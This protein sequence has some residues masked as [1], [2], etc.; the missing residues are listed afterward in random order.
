MDQIFVGASMA[1]PVH[2]FPEEV[3]RLALDALNLAKASIL[4][5]NHFLSSA[6]AR[7]TV[8]PARLGVSFA[9]DGFVLAFDCACVLA[10]FKR[11][12][13]P[14]QH[15]LLHSI[16]H[17]LFLHPYRGAVEPALWDLACDIA[18]ERVVAELLGPRKGAR[19]TGIARIV[20]RVE[21]DMC[22]RADAERLYRE[23]SRGRWESEIA[24][25]ADLTAR[26]SHMLWYAESD[27]P[28]DFQGNATSGRT[29][30]SGAKTAQSGPEDSTART[31]ASDRQAHE[32]PEQD[33]FDESDATSSAQIREAIATRNS[34]SGSDPASASSAYRDGG[35]SQDQHPTASGAA[36]LAPQQA[37][38]TR[39][40][41]DRA[42][43]KGEWRDEA[44]SLAIHLQTLAA[45]TGSRLTEFVADLEGA[46]RTADDY[47]DFL[48][49]F[50]AYGEVMRISEDEFDYNFYT[51]GM[52]LYGDTPLI[53]PLEYRDERRIR[54]FVVV[55]D[56]SESV[57]G[58]AV[59]AFVRATFNVL[60]T[61][62]AFFDRICLR[63]LQCDNRVLAD[64]VIRDPND[65][66][67]WSDGMKIRGGGGTDFRPA[68]DYIDHLVDDGQLHSVDGLLYFTDGL[69]IYPD[70]APAYK[71]AFVFYDE[72]LIGNE[73]PAW[74]LRVLLD[75]GSLRRAGQPD[76]GKE[77]QWI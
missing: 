68:F 35:P 8:R 11:D 16:V 55:I 10:A 73:V 14:S 60:K 74:A 20:S 47:V 37:A 52:S 31:L 42:R 43:S 36:P 17:C 48:R 2:P 76:G 3:E 50:G 34:S 53:E 63:V 26:D 40:D 22:G 38:A 28:C 27:S 71:T 29:P 59:R 18:S 67:A 77:T 1:Q 65:L 46:V 66:G 62:E 69:G 57:Q 64:E 13:G 19:G 30:G 33:G 24:H 41:P 58:H 5:D 51:Y 70:Q 4:I 45:G 44:T 54:E 6:I 12:R 32:T 21:R 7:L 61:T 49:S 23:L 72:D 75:E 39:I 15:D 25:W 9:T 56:T